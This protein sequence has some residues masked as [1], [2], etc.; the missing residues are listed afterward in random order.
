[1][2]VAF[3]RASHELHVVN[4]FPRPPTVSAEWRHLVSELPRAERWPEHARLTERGWQAYHTMVTTLT[5]PEDDREID[6]VDFFNAPS[7]WNT[8]L[9]S[10]R[11][12][13]GQSRSLA[14]ICQNNKHAPKQ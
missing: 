2:A 10:Q 13:D 8:L 3:S 14:K 4:G 5:K 1:M 12:T 7:H 11:A 9:T 6:V